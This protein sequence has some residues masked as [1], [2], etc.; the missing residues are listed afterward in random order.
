MSTSCRPLTGHDD[1]SE[2]SAEDQYARALHGLEQCKFNDA[3]DAALMTTKLQPDWCDLTTLYW[4]VHVACIGKYRTAQHPY[5]LH[6]GYISSQQSMR[7]SRAKGWVAL[8]EAQMGMGHYRAS[9]LAYRQD[10]ARLHRT[11]E[12]PRVT[13]CSQ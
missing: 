13:H 8:G 9:L 2:N 6:A 3:V 7:V 11:A 5:V 1:A 4:Y 12:P 10:H